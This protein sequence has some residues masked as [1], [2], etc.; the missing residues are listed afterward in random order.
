MSHWGRLWPLL[1][2]HRGAYA[3]GLSLITAAAGCGILV[4]RILRH[5]VERL[6]LHQATRDFIVWSSVAI[7]L[8]AVVRG[9]L[10]F[11]GRYLILTAARRVEYDLRNDLFAH[12]ETLS[13]RWYDTHATGDITSR[14][15]NDLEGVRMMVGIGIM[16]LC[17]TGLL[18]L[19]ALTSMFL[20]EPRLAALCAIPLAA[21]SAVMAWTGAKMH[22]LSMGVQ[23]QLSVLSSRA[24]ENFS[25]ARVVRAFAQEEN[26]VARF[27][28]ACGEYRRRNLELAAWRSGT[29][30]TVLILAE[31]AIVITLFVGG[32]W[33][34]EGTFTK[35]RLAEFT[36]YQFMLVWPM[37]AIGWLI[38]VAQR[39]VVCLKR[40][41]EF[42][43]S[44]PETDD[45]RAVAGG[46]PV[47]GLIEARGLSFSYSPDR[48]PALRDLSLRIE[49]GSKVALVG[50]TGAGK[51]TFLNL[52]LRLYRVPEG[53]LFLDGRDVTTIP[54]AELRAAIGTVPQD[55]F[56]FSDRLRENIAFGGANGVSDDAVL[57]AAEISRLSADVERFPGKYDQLI[58]ERG[59]KL[60]GGQKQRAALARALVR[61]PRI[62]ILDDALS[63]VDAHT[64]REIQDRLREYMRGRTCL[65]VTHRLAAITDADHILV[66][67][68]GRVAEEGTHAGLVAR[69]GIYAG[70]W[71]SQ[72]LA[73][74][75]YR[76]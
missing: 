3:L 46:P 22:G 76:S 39:G 54:L 6:E 29:W 42:F 51:S 15:I 40:L 10:L 28:S 70:L 48:P 14:A 61:E 31:A 47:E 58:G 44:K 71:E 66:M 38:T 65:V 21:I 12:L 13:A 32:R 73:E 35:G 60:S 9:S 37:I 27:R 24:Q 43:N 49:P 75:L 30:A 59:V 74:E 45:A 62:L 25:G 17:S 68:E 19:G 26:E 36:A 50:R 56:L 67:D 5:A 23:D 1:R 57:R 18:S 33:M 8:F 4:P 64:E 16:S 2:R 55:L 7:A 63:S 53:M 41:E 69:R 34:T 11:G 72:R 52:L 20:M